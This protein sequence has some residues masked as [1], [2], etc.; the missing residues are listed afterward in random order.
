MTFIISQESWIYSSL[1]AVALGMYVVLM[2]PI[3][4][5]TFKEKH[6]N[7]WSNLALV[8]VLVTIAILYILP[9]S[10]WGHYAYYPVSYW[11]IVFMSAWGLITLIGYILLKPSSERESNACLQKG[12]ECVDKYHIDVLNFGY[13]GEVRRKVL[14]LMALITLFAFSIGHMV[15]W[16][17]NNFS[18]VSM[19]AMVSP[20]NYYGVA[21]LYTQ[22]PYIQGA[23]ILN[24][25]LFGAFCVQ[26]NCEILRLRYSKVNFAFKRTMQKTRRASEARSFGAHIS[27]LPTFLLG[28]MILTYSPDHIIEGVWATYAVITVSTLADLMA[29]LIGRRYGKHKWHIFEGKSIEG[30]LAGSITAFFAAV[31]FVGPI[32]A[33]VAVVVFN[34]TDLGLA[35]VRISDN[36]TTPLL[37]AIAF[38]LLIFLYIPVVNQ[39][40][41][42]PEWM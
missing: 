24:L 20:E 26:A 3:V 33:G 32:L 1:L 41:Y 25:G 37:L 7:R 34:F 13:S 21:Y 11:A 27:L 36:L 28:G 12:L 42:I 17:I 31:F 22:P 4:W 2:M 39:F 16:L 38:R 40:F 35:K 8:L 6:P 5:R 30:S 19:Q 14:H 10:A 15:F 29:A 18:Y 9:D 23:I